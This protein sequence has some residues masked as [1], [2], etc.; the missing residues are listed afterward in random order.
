MEFNRL[1]SNRLNSYII[2][3]TKSINPL[4]SGSGGPPAFQPRNNWHNRRQHNRICAIGPRRAVNG[5]LH[6]DFANK[7]RD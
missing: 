3:C 6:W 1:K 7:N 4:Y 5:E 2:D